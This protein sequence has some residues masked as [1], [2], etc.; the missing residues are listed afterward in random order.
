MAPAP[1]FRLVLGNSKLTGRSVLSTCVGLPNFRSLLRR[2]LANAS[3][4][5]LRLRP[6]RR[7]TE[8]PSAVAPPAQLRRSAISS[9]FL[10]CPLPCERIFRRWVPAAFATSC[11]QLRSWPYSAGSPL[12]VTSLVSFQPE[13]ILKFVRTHAVTAWCLL[14]GG[15]QVALA[16]DLRLSRARGAPYIPDCPKPETWHPT[17][18]SQRLSGSRVAQISLVCSFFYFALPSL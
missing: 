6:P 16:V 5:R 17:P 1:S 2:L 15:P 3:R 4:S 12:L 10:P 18:S 8:W 14:Q 7:R 9:F 13:P 11:D